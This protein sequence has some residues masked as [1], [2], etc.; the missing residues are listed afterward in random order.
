MDSERKHDGE[1]IIAGIIFFESEAAFIRFPLC[2]KILLRTFQSR[3][4]F[5][6]IVFFFSLSFFFVMVEL[7]ECVVLK[8]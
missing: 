3:K 6:N 4:L 1:W 2:P 7:S 5:T 8:H